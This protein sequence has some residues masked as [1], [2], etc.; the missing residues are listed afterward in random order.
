MNLK[1]QK[2]IARLTK[3]GYNPEVLRGY[4][5]YDLQNPDDTNLRELEKAIDILLSDDCLTPINRAL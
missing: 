2:Q 1:K 3:A 4:P 5:G